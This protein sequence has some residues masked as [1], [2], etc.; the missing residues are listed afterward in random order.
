MTS[1]VFEKL[2]QSLAANQTWPLQIAGD[3]FRV[4]SAEWPVTVEIMSGGRI[5]G[6]MT[7]VRA[8]DFVRDI[9]FDQV[10]VINGATAQS[11]TVQIAGGGVGSDRVI[12]E[13]SVIDGGKSRTFA[14]QAF[15]Y[16]LGVAPGAGLYALFQMQNPVGSAKNVIVKTYKIAAQAAGVV[17]VALNDAPLQADLSGVASKLIGSEN[18]PALKF[19][20]GAVAGAMGP[21]YFDIAN[22]QANAEI[23]KVL[24]EPWVLTPGTTMK[25][26]SATAEQ[27]LN[28]VFEWI[29][30]AI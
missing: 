9:V 10:R 30:E 11:V 15:Q 3:F 8:G 16:G 24:Q 7:N 29:E 14:G 17:A 20:G 2:A 26:H 4:E 18:V 5:V 21:N 12:G 6:R 28:C 1:L 13:V 25:I 19:Y 27:T 23:S 22:L